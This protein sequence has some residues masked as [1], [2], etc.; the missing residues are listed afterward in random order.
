MAHILH[1]IHKNYYTAL[2]SSPH[3]EPMVY[4][5]NVPQRYMFIIMH[6]ITTGDFSYRAGLDFRPLFHLQSPQHSSMSKHLVTAAREHSSLR[7][8]LKQNRDLGGQPY[9]LTSW[10][11]RERRRG[12][13]KRETQLK[14]NNDNYRTVADNMIPSTV[15]LLL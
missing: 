15:C 1:K 3:G 6:Q 11:K 14:H 2:S 10:A 7:G 13:E 4:C 9:T 12:R 8:N 5:H